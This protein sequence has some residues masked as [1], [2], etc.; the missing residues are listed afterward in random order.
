MK[1]ESG[2]E[3]FPDTGYALVQY[4][5]PGTSAGGIITP[6]MAEAANARYVLIEA[7][8]GQVIDGCFVATELQQGDQLHITMKVI[9]VQDPHTKKRVKQAVVAS[10]KVA[11]APDDVRLIMLNDVCAYVRKAKH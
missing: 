6:A 1:L 9:E 7:S 8:R 10:E 3:L 4:I 11:G 5:A 2:D